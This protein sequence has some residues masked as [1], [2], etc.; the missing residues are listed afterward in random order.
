MDVMMTSLRWMNLSRLD[1]VEQRLVLEV[2][3]QDLAGSCYLGKTY[4]G[5]SR[6]LVLLCQSR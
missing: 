1:S 3:L 4:V 5:H 6:L 2:V